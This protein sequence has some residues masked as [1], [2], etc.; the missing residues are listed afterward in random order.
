VSLEPVASAVTVKGAAPELGVTANCA[1]GGASGP[2]VGVGDGVLVGVGVGVGVG[3]LVGLAD[4]LVGCTAGFFAP[5][6]GTA[7]GGTVGEACVVGDG[8]PA[9]GSSVVITASAATWGVGVAFAPTR[10]RCSARV[11]TKKGSAIAT[12][13]TVA[14]I[15]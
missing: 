4:G 11:K 2:G 15:E 5:A 1:T 14:P 7:F 13:R 9:V 6:V 3:A 12:T 10:Y 8:A